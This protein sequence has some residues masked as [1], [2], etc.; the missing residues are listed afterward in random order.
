[1]LNPPRC[2][3]PAQQSATI[4]L[5]RGVCKLVCLAAPGDVARA[6]GSSCRAKRRG[7]GRR[8]CRRLLVLLVIKSS[9]RARP[10]LAQAVWPATTPGP[11]ARVGARVCGAGGGGGLARGGGGQARA[12]QLWLAAGRRAPRRAAALAPAQ[13]V[14]APACAAAASAGL[15]ARRAGLRSVPL[16]RARGRR[17]AGV[18]RRSRSSCAVGGRQLEMQAPPPAPTPVHTYPHSTVAAS[19]PNARAPSSRSG[20]ARLGADAPGGPHMRRRRP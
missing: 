12:W 14:A 9:M 20:A 6:S 3:S 19:F 16:A 18:R 1:M 10:G 15:G 2:H 4:P 7:G 17:R 5:R 11:R 8:A 13:R